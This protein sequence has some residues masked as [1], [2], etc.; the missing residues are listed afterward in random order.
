MSR[1]DD[2]LIKAVEESEASAA[3]A[4]QVLDAPRSADVDAT[5]PKRSVGLLVALLV[6]AA[7]ILTLVMTS[8]DQAMV[9]AKDADK[10]V[11]E[12]DQLRGRNVRVQGTLVNGSLRRRDQPCEYRFTIEKNGAEVPVS[13]PQ[14]VVPDN[15][16]DIPGMP[17][18][19]TA[20][21]KLG[22]DGT[23][24]A[25]HIIAQCPSKY[26]ERAARGEKLPYSAAVPTI[27]GS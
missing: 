2:E 23:F 17:V 16:R 12:R 24:A 22:D 21:G 11:A 25:S 1:L 26:E 14:C 10:L 13:F 7:G 27:G 9:Y 5:R 20:E 18:K 8:V 4:P 3:A 6:M 15:F 19:V